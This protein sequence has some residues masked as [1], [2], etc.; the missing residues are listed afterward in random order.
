MYLDQVILEQKRGKARG[1]ASICSAHPLVLKAAM[2][3]QPETLLIEA[4]CNQVNQFGG[5]TGMTPWDFAAYVRKIAN[6]NHYPFEKIILG[7]DHLGPNVWQDEPAESAMQKSEEMVRLYVQAGFCKIHIDCSMQLAGDRGRTLDVEVS[8]S[9]SARLVKAA[10]QAAA[11]GGRDFGEKRLRYIIGTEVPVPGGAHEHEEGVS[12]TRVADVQQTID[13]TRRAFIEAGIMDTWERVAGVVVQPGV[14]FG[15]D[16]VLPY[17]PEKAEL[18]T[19]FI[20]GQPLVYEAHSTDYQTRQVLSNLVRDH[21]AILKV[22]PGLTFAYREA[23]FALAM[24]ENELV[25]AGQCSNMM[26]VLDDVMVQ[27]PNYWKKY[28]PGTATEQAFKR[29]Y[30]L[31]DRVRYYWVQPRVQAALDQLMRNLKGANIPAS[32]LSQ[33]LPL[34]Y[35]R[36]SAGEMEPSPNAVLVDAVQRVLSD[37]RAATA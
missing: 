22:G 32:L 29:K 17:Q 21:F 37:Y 36:V 23:V 6:E 4:T 26:Q 3:Q 19:R 2:L 27:Q 1:I 14:E 28:Y 31:S 11:G 10:E 30:S 7:G 33:F 13:V 20:E 5:Y 16:F 8:A 24:I 9:R 18:L 34:Q 15:D 35:Q 25:E 12:V